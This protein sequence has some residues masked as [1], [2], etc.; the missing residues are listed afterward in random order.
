MIEFEDSEEVLPGEKMTDEQIEMIKDGKELGA[1]NPSCFGYHVIGMYEGH[2]E[3]CDGNEVLRF[4]TIE[5]LQRFLVG[6]EAEYQYFKR[7]EV[8]SAIR[9]EQ[10][11]TDF[12]GEWAYLDD[13][14]YR[15]IADEFDKYEIPIV[16]DIPCKCKGN[17]AILTRSELMINLWD[18]TKDGYK[19]H[20]CGS[21]S[22]E[23][24]VNSLWFLPHS[25]WIGAIWYL[26]RSDIDETLEERLAEYEVTANDGLDAI[27][28]IF[29]TLEEG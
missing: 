9:E 27:C 8:L 11:F 14:G 7:R 18:D 5:D 26:E 24:D 13:Y 19:C 21:Y 15:K 10:V 17:R 16:G 22:S 20:A 25:K 2:F 29:R 1:Y 28:E 23:E 12:K 4:D 6:E 3:Y